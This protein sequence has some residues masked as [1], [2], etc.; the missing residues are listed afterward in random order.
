MLNIK[1]KLRLEIY[2][3]RDILDLIISLEEKKNL[4]EHDKISERYYLKYIN[5]K[6]NMNYKNL[7]N[8]IDDIFKNNDE[9]DNTI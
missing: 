5:A 3:E 2:R 1:K 7:K 6:Y 8:L 9:N 4:T